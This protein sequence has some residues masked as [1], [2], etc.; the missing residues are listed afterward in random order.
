VFGSKKKKSP[1]SS[2]DSGSRL[3]SWMGNLAVF[4][5]TLL[6][7]ISIPF[8]V[9]ALIL[10]FRTVMDYHVWILAGITAITA[11]TLVFLIRRRKQIREQ[12][13]AEKKDVMKIIR[14]AAQ[15]GHNVNI[16]FMR[17]LIS[18]DYRGS[19]NDGRLLEG[20]KLSQLKALP[21]STSGNES[22]EIM[23]DNSKDL[24][25]TQTPGIA[26][27]LEKLSGLLEKGLLTEA[28]YQELKTRLIDHKLSNLNLY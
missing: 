14:S 24:S 5:V 8:L 9:L 6:A 26:S 27:E 7:L 25:E 1:S 2:T 20:S 11:V 4:Y 3:F 21:L 13:E 17:G 10:F 12:Y 16:S 18:L 22:E 19:N 23:L 28:E 15:E